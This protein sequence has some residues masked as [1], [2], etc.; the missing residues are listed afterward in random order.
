MAQIPASIHNLAKI[1]W[2]YHRLD[3]PLEPADAILVLCSY[4]KRVAERAAQ[5]W[6]D[7]WAP[8]LIFS[9]G[10]GVITRALWSEPEADQFAQ[11]ALNMGVPAEAILIENQSTNTGENVIFTRQLLAERN[12]DPASFLLIQKPYMERR[13]YA[14]F[15]KVWPEKLARVTSPQVSYEEYLHS[16]SNPDLS[17][18]Q[19][20]HIMVGD[21]Q[22]IRE[23][24]EK[25]FQI[26]QEIPQEVW[27]AYKTLVNAG[28]NQHLIKE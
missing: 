20:I 11:I 6:L 13:S 24:P 3:Q 12:L 21:L 2:N 17:P 5:L 19:I 27:E 10:L 28:Y 8:L 4:D 14:T 16:Y 9:G 26:P 25:G 1:L 15:R 22:R 18:E 7:G 23:Y